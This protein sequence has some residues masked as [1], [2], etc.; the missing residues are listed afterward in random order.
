MDGS[1]RSRWTSAAEPLSAESARRRA[2]ASTAPT[3]CSTPAVLT[4][5]AP[6][7]SCL[8]RAGLAQRRE[9]VGRL[10]EAR[11][12]GEHDQLVIS[13]AESVHGRPET[14]PAPVPEPSPCGA[15]GPPSRPRA[16][17]DPDSAGSG[18]GRSRS[19]G[20]AA[21]SAAGTDRLTGFGV[22]GPRNQLPAPVSQAQ[23][24]RAPPRT[25]RMARRAPFGRT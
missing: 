24:A 25:P 13:R 18:R 3:A 20:G 17:G 23:T 8:R 22:S 12:F 14:P 9:Q 21:R 19:A 1:P 7:R 5:A 11:E 10:L 6:A 4:G 16:A 15:D 2:A